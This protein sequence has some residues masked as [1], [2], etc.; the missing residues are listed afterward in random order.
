MFIAK[1][2]PQKK[3][4]N[5][6]LWELPPDWLLVS[7]L[8][9]MPSWPQQTSISINDLQPPLSP[10]KTVYDKPNMLLYHR[11]LWACLSSQCHLLGTSRC[12]LLPK[13]CD[14]VEEAGHIASTFYHSSRMNTSVTLPRVPRDKS[15][16]QLLFTEKYFDT[17]AGH[18][19]V[20]KLVEVIYFHEFAKHTQRRGTCDAKLLWIS[21]S[22]TLLLNIPRH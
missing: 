19:H 3:K 6:S 21:R 5:V 12:L 16:M 8:I 14:T 9:K 17:K 13:L 4:K 22:W 1:N 7:S 18:Y 10:R 20:A 11:W 15:A 2:V